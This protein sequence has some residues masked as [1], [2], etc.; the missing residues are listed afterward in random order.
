MVDSEV[1]TKRTPNIPCVCVILVWQ[2][3]VYFLLVTYPDLTLLSVR[4]TSFRFGYHY[5]TEVLYKRCGGEKECGFPNHLWGQWRQH[6]IKIV[7]QSAP[8]CSRMLQSTPECSRVLQS[9][10]KCPEEKVGITNTFLAFIIQKHN[11]GAIR[12]RSRFF[13]IFRKK[14]TQTR[15]VTL[16]AEGVAYLRKKIN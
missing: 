12:A 15:F 6:K 1:A 11:L 10:S 9:T 3:F 5:A 14:R 4:R 13:V 8:E 7:L 2:L 16:F